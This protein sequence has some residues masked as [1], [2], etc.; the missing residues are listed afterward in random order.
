MTSYQPTSRSLVLL[1]AAGL[2][3]LFL[4]A[5]GSSESVE[6]AVANEPAP[7]TTTTTTESG[8]PTPE[9]V[10]DPSGDGDGPDSEPEG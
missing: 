7:V 9:L 5:C 6:P 3:A 1:G 10:P 8:L 4:A 2:S